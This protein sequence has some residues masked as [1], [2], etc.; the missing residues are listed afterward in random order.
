MFIHKPYE[1]PKLVQITLPS[2]IRFYETPEGNKYPSVT[3]ILSE[4]L[5]KEG[6]KDWRERVGD[7]EADRIMKYAGERGTKVHKKCEDYLYSYIRNED[8]YETMEEY[9]VEPFNK[10]RKVI[11]EKVKIVHN[12]EFPVYSNIIKTAG[13]CDLF[14]TYDG[15]PSIIDFKTSLR[16][17]KEEWIDKYFYQV[18]CYAMMVYEIHGVIIPQTVVIIAS[19]G[20][21]KAQ[22][23][24]KKTSE[25]VEATSKTFQK[26]YSEPPDWLPST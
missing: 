1:F 7:E 18:T 24:V 19:D 25:Y 6:L 12:T 26:F 10:I 20:V 2:G 5:S 8:V 15:V 13:T 14:A 11:D 4:T 22:V 23:F 17:K 3:T 16:Y 9:I 21:E